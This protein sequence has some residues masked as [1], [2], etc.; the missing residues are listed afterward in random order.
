MRMCA[1]L[2]KPVLFQKKIKK[3]YIYN[4]LC[5]F[6][7]RYIVFKKIKEKNDIENMKKLPVIIPHN[8]TPAF[9]VCVLARLPKRLRNRNPVPPKAP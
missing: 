7:V 5:N 1:A 8:R 4:L 2:K 9:F 3:I 6:S